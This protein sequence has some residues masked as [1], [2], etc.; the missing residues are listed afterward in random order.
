M[1]AG[2]IP[3]ILNTIAAVIFWWAYQYIRQWVQFDIDSYSNYTKCLDSRVLHG[4]RCD[5]GY[6]NNICIDSISVFFNIMFP[7]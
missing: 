3:Y 2:K 4:E 5:S 7:Y 6:L 1:L